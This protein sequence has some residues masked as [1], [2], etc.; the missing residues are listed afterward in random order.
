MKKFLAVF[1]ICSILLA[2][3]LAGLSVLPHAHGN[4]LDHSQH[5]SCAVYQFSLGHTDALTATII[6]SLL[7]FVAFR[8]FIPEAQLSSERFFHFHPLRAPPTAS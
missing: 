4:D 6:F 5:K 2:S 3:G 8:S 1:A 7:L